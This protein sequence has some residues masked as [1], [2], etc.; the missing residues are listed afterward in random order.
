MSPTEENR[1]QCHSGY[2]FHVFTS[3][4]GSVS[5]VHLTVYW[6]HI[7]KV[8]SCE[9]VSQRFKTMSVCDRCWSQIP[10]IEMTWVH[11]NSGAIAQT[12]RMPRT[13]NTSRLWSVTAYARNR[14]RATDT[15]VIALLLRK[16]YYALPWLPIMAGMIRASM[17][18]DMALHVLINFKLLCSNKCSRLTA[19][20]MSYI[21]I[22]K[23][24]ERII[25]EEM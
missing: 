12:P 7:W 6:T 10:V 1:Q 21:C 11:T 20:T 14:R 13:D 3:D 2:H 15:R 5:I 23:N 9:L 8:W 24:H 4:D 17:K 19:I 18:R 25:P 22:N 16:R